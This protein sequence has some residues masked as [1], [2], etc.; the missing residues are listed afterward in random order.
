MNTVDDL[1]AFKTEQIRQKTTRLFETVKQHIK[2]IGSRPRSSIIIECCAEEGDLQ[3]MRQLYP[4]FT[5][6]TVDYDSHVLIIH[7]KDTKSQ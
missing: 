3:V 5:F 2:E 1:I 7:L 6:Y 4:A